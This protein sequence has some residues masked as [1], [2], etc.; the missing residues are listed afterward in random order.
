MAY[1]L[2]DE[3]EN[4]K[5]FQLQSIDNQLVKSFALIPDTFDQSTVS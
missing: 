3:F 5:K 4:V 2:L 1:N